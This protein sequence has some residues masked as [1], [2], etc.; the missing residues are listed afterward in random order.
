[1][2]GTAVLGVVVLLAAAVLPA[3][4]AAVAHDPS[5]D[6]HCLWALE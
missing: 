6:T 1:M 3:P 2:Q 4:V 5:G